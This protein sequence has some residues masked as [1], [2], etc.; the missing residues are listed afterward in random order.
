MEKND[1]YL[2]YTT[3]ATHAEASQLAKDL[4]AAHLAACVQIGQ[5]STSVY[6]WDGRLEVCDEV[7]LTIKT[8]G[9][10]VDALKDWLEAHHSYEVPE[11]L[12]VRVADGMAAYKA[13]AE[14]WLLDKTQ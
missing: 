11:L 2:G 12:L 4:V 8:H 14:D 10:K 13:W 9:C 5:A 1:L 3:C 6:P 7:V